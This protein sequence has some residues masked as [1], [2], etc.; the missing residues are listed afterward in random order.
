M[1]LRP[2]GSYG[3]LKYDDLIG[4]EFIPHI[5]I[6]IYII[7]AQINQIRSVKVSIGSIIIRFVVIVVIV[8][9]ISILMIIPM[10]HAH[11]SDTSTVN[12]IIYER[13][14]SL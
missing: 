2:N 13:L 14:L 4:L 7:Y 1:N 5:Y 12:I 9:I 3:S 10:I 8:I 11:M 6:Y